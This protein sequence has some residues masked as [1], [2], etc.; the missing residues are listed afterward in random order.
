MRIKSQNGF[1]L[2]ELMITMVVFVL[3]MVAA[4]NIFTGLLTQFKQQSRIAESNIEGIAGLELM[5]HDLEQAGFG[6]LWNLNGATYSE[7]A[8]DATYDPTNTDA[9]VAAVSANSYNDSTGNVP[10]AVVIGNNVLMNG[11]DVLVIKATNIA[12]TAAS[13]KWEYI[14][15]NGNLPNYLR[16][17]GGATLNPSEK[18]ST[19]DRVIIINPAAGSNINNQRVL[20]NNGG[21]FD[22]QLNSDFSCVNSANY[23]S[24]F[25][26]PQ[27]SY[28]AY[29]AYGISPDC[30]N[31]P[32]LRMPF[33]R[34]DFFIKRTPDIPSR[35]APGT[36]VL[37]KATVNQADGK[38]TELPLLDCVLD[39]QVVVGFDASGGGSVT[40]W[41]GKETDAAILPDGLTAGQIRD[42][43]KEIRVYLVVQEGQK[44]TS[45]TSPSATLD[46][47]DPNLTDPVKT[48]H[49]DT[50]VGATEYKYYRWKLHTIAITPYNLR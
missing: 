19:T 35:C 43:L 39:M 8:D 30:S 41:V 47:K 5:R 9:T 27:N 48:V 40:D 38:L 20:I 26:P 33:N 22:V 21:A 50:I 17:W 28:T 14:V 4:S 16:D 6:L 11:S 31:P 23:K 3:A 13:Q 45:Y 7:A 42:Q 25:E 12:T 10:R 34:A 2:V 44:D 24:P 32:C 1:T 49:L 46:I 37:Y 18:L 36:G 29:L 15:N